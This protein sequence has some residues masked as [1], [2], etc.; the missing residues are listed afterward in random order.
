MH[1]SQEACIVLCCVDIKAA[2]FNRLSSNYIHNQLVLF[3]Y[4]FFF[5]IHLAFF[6]ASFK[7]LPQVRFQIKSNS[8]LFDSKH[9]PCV[10]GT[11]PLNMGS[12]PLTAELPGHPRS[13]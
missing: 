10:Q 11:Q 13:I 4:F 2:M 6:M 7:Q 12:M 8:I 5:R 1:T 3:E 9:R